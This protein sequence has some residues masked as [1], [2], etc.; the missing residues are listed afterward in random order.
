MRALWLLA[1]LLFSLLPSPAA[2]GVRA[3]VP[4]LA[5]YEAAPHPGAGD[6]LRVAGGFE[7]VAA[8]EQGRAR[9]K[10]PRSAGLDPWAP[11]PS[12]VAPLRSVAHAD[13]LPTPPGSTPLCERLPYQATAPPS[14][15]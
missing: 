3:P 6:Q 13:G 4:D 1:M 2:A 15:G 8:R 5:H 10:N 14:R 11:S 12:A 7:A 9:W